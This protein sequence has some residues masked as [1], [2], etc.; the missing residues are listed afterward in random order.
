ME[1]VTKNILVTGVGGPAGI[2]AARLFKKEENVQIIGC[3]IDENSTG[4]F[5]VDTFLISPRASE[6]DAYEKWM[7]ETVKK[8]EIDILIPTVHDELPIL[9]TFCDDLPCEVI[10]SESNVIALGDDKKLT[11]E[12]AEKNLPQNIIRNVL[13]SEWTEGWSS[14]NEQFIKPRKGRGARGCKVVTKDELVWLKA[15]TKDTDS[16]IVM[17]NMPGTEWTVDAYVGRDGTHVYTVARERMGLAGGI[18]I[19]GRTVKN[20]A[21]LNVT[22]MM[23]DALQCRG[24]VCIQWKEDSEGT[25]RLIE[26][27]PRLSGGLLISVHAGV[28]PISNILREHKGEKLE[29][30]MWNEVTVLGYY[31]YTLRK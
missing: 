1:M 22:K 7:R 10:I 3:D 14:D 24:P 5:F 19:K 23:L 28:N 27:N 12:W 15:H 29:R 4:K 31:E 25:P 6:S 17:E 16:Y 13:L 8:Y 11:Y 26:I 2:N 9:R 21:V 20:E 30:Q 18:S